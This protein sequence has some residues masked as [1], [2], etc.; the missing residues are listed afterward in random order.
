MAR[1]GGSVP[2]ETMVKVYGDSG[3]YAKDA[4]KLGKQGWSVSNTTHRQPRAGIGRIVTLGML[5][6]IR[7]PKPELVVTYQRSRTVAAPS[8]P[9]HSVPLPAGTAEKG[10]GSPLRTIV[11]VAVVLVVILMILA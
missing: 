2:V 3:T 4:K 5:T 6:A 10:G 7:P 1:R 11:I 8:R 9:S